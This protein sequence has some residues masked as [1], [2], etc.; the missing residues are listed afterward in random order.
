MQGSVIY[1]Y[2][3]YRPQSG[4]VSPLILL[5]EHIAGHDSDGPTLVLAP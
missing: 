4:K 2:V 3:R 5:A 1:Q